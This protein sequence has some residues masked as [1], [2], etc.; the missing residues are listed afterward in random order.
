MGIRASSP[1]IHQ[2]SSFPTLRCCCS[3][4]FCFVFNLPL[5][6][7]TPEFPP[8][9][10]W[11]NHLKTVLADGEDNGLAACKLAYLCL[12]F[13]ENRTHLHVRSKIWLTEN[14]SLDVILLTESFGT[15]AKITLKKELI[16]IELSFC[17]HNF[18][19]GFGFFLTV[20]TF[21]N[22]HQR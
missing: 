15:V 22:W 19:K 3:R 6:T 5:M 2:Q 10:K 7:C 13:V 9:K 12:W 1:T 21:V 16:K 18:V 14:I 17:V 4:C 20:I 8:E 11:L